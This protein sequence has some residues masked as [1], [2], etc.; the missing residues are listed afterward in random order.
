MEP[1]KKRPKAH[2]KRQ[3]PENVTRLGLPAPATPA[4][5]EDWL[6]G[7]AANKQSRIVLLAPLPE[8]RKPA[9]G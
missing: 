5:A 3:T 1:P 6:F 7:L 8:E 9:I 2:P 4:A